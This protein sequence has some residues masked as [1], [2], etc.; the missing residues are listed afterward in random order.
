MLTMM[1]IAHLLGDYLF[2]FNFIARWK[3][4]SIW[5]VV[6][7]GGIVTLCSL[8]CAAIVDVAWWPY[9]LLIGITHT[10]I[11]VIRARMIHT[12]DPQ[13]DLFYYLLD[14]M[15]HV[16]IIIGLVWQSGILHARPHTLLGALLTPQHLALITGYLLLLQPG[17]VLLRFIVRG[18]WGE[19]AAPNLTSGE[20]FAPMVERVL[21][22]SAVLTGPFYLVPVILIPRRLTVVQIQS[23]GLGIHIQLTTH[24]AETFLSVL[25]AVCVGAVLRV[26]M[27]G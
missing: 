16:V 1:L 7:H 12:Q 23:N 18:I 11:D 4:R 15:L 5:G 3:M 21:I 14:Q 2:Q 13:H 27:I 9:A 6:A 24:W 22:A 17:W 26:L 19:D 10:I 8:I 20:K 25:L